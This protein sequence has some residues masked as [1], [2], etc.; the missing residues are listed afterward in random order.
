MEGCFLIH[1]PKFEYS[2][3]C[4]FGSPNFLNTK[5]TYS[6][7]VAFT[8]LQESSYITKG[9]TTQHFLRSSFF[10]SFSSL[11]VSES[12]NFTLNFGCL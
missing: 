8:V 2:S 11:K 12:A 4:A 9:F 6:L 10:S 7:M 3:F 1:P 5:L